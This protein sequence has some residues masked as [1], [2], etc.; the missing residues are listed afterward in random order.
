MHIIS[1]K[2]LQNFWAEHPDAKT[3]LAVWYKIMKGTLFSSLPHLREV[4]PH[5]D[6]VDDLT[7]FNI[8]GNKFRLI[9]AVHYN[10]SKVYIRD[11]LT[12]AEYDKA[13]WKRR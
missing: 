9:T 13:R 5:A 2:K 4:F 8:C 6:V 11:V 1:K 10:R 12:H 7:V 3:G